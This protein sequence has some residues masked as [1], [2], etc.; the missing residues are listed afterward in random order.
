MTKKYS[1]NDISISVFHQLLKPLLH[2]S[3]FWTDIPI[4]ILLTLKLSP[5]RHLLTLKLSPNRHFLILKLSLNRHLLTLELSPIRHLLTLELS[6]IRHLL[7][8][9]LSPNRHLLTLKL[10]PFFCI[11]V[12]GQIIKRDSWVKNLSPCYPFFLARNQKPSDIHHRWCCSVASVQTRLCEH[13][14]FFQRASIF[15]NWKKIIWKTFLNSSLGS[16]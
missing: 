3:K 10:S 7:T 5:N 12:F 16:L 14:L 6:P 11:T 13:I 1:I 9:K 8:L 2:G 4:S 15:I